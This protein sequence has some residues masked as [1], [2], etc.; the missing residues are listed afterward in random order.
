MFHSLKLK[1]DWT[2]TL[3]SAKRHLS[4]KYIIRTDVVAA[5]WCRLWDQAL[6]LG[7]K[8]TGLILSS[9]CRPVFGDCLCSYCGNEIPSNQIFFDHLCS[10][11]LH[12]EYNQS[13][14]EILTEGGQNV[15]DMAT[16]I[17]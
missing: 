7:T 6:D 17:V 1:Q 8:G 3:K 5:S 10:E 16:V 2:H 14:G 15:F 13:I 4:L 11:H 9:L 12:R